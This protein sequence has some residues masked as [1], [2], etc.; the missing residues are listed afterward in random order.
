MSKD[1]DF[2]MV[3]KTFFGLEDVL[4]KELLTLGARNIK[5]GVRNVSFYGDK[6]FL[7]KSNSSQIFKI[8]GSLF[9]KF[10]F[11]ENEVLG[12]LIFSLLMGL[13]LF[14]NLF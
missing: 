8:S 10:A 3:G 7:Y 1:L 4:A 12:K 6:G 13:T 2:K 9:G 14:L 11:I 5:I